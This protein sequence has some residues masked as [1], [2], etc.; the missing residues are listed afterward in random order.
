MAAICMSYLTHTAFAIDQTA[1]EETTPPDAAGPLT[2]DQI[3]PVSSALPTNAPGQ[4]PKSAM[5]T[6]TANQ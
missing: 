2:A 5:P 1:K 3:P 6:P 4:Q